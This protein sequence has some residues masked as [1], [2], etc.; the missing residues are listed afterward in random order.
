MK[1]PS[2]PPLFLAVQCASTLIACHLSAVAWLL[3]DQQEQL[4]A[5][6][7]APKALE[8]AERLAAEDWQL[9]PGAIICKAGPRP[10]TVWQAGEPW[11][12]AAT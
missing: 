5:A 12:G 2:L 9:S 7:A 1:A 10:F 3:G 4:Q 11:G 8:A 6:L